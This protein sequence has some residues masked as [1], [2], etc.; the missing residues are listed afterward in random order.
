MTLRFATRIL[1]LPLIALLHSVVLLGNATMKEGYV[2]PPQQN[3]PNSRAT[4]GCAITMLSDTEGVDFN[5]YLRDAYLSVKKRWFS[6]MPTS[7]EKG[8]QGTNT[9]EFRVLQGGTIPKDSIKMT[10]RSEKS[11]FDAASVEGIQ[12]AAPLGHLPEKFSKPFIMLRFTF[13]YNLSVPKNPQ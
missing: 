6:N 7:V 5:S 9:V 12:E 1:I 10:V 4:A 8:Q 13:Y 11:D 2:D 3:G